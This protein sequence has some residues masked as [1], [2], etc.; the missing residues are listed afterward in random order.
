MTRGHTAKSQRRSPISKRFTPSHG[1]RQTLTG[2]SW[3]AMMS[4]CFNPKYNVH[5]NYGAVGITVCDFLR[6]TPLALVECIGPRP[7]HLH[8]IDRIDNVGHYSCGQCKHCRSHGWGKNVRW[9]TVT[10]QG[11]NRS[12]NVQVTINGETKTVTQWATASG[13]K[14]HTIFNRL[15]RGLKGSALLEP[16]K[17]NTRFA[18]IGGRRMSVGDHAKRLG[19]CKNA[20]QFRLK[21]G[22][23]EAQLNLPKQK[24]RQVHK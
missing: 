21:S 3:S 8:S 20:L 24:P 19:I 14:R 23:T 15:K 13:I 2:N 10:E 6:T 9:A 22:W 12:T 17:D 16:P 5:Q 7:S 1:L 4:R 11:N 18:V